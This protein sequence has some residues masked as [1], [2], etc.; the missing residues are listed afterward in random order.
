LGGWATS[1]LLQNA[2]FARGDTKGPAWIAAVRVA[3]AAGLGVVLMF[4][5]DQFGVIDAQIER[6]GDLPAALRPLPDA[7][8]DDG[9]VR[10]GAVG[11]SLASGV[12]SW[13]EL[14]LLR[15]R[16]RHAVGESPAIALPLARLAPAAAA[17]V[18]VLV[19]VRFATDW[20]PSVLQAT[21]TVGAGGLA[22]VAAARITGV[23]EARTSLSAVL[24]RE[25]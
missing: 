8:R 1:R 13:V 24:R 9:V 22:Y 3:L 16:L 6:L 5:L 2:L 18:L 12:A 10:L 14:G 11:L 15:R 20:L 19:G 25:R 21:L 7:V 4:Q 17:A 23:A